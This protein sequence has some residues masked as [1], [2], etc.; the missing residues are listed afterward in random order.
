MGWGRLK[1]NFLCV[2]T[3]LVTPTKDITLVSA[4][5][6]SCESTVSRHQGH[7]TKS[8]WTKCQGTM[9]QGTRIQ[10][11]TVASRCVASKYPPVDDG[12]GNI[13]SSIASNTTLETKFWCPSVSTIKPRLQRPTVNSHRSYTYRSKAVAWIRFQP[14]KSNLKQRI[15]MLVFT[16]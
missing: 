6:D 16:A 3:V 10:G 11:T 7:G 1:P 2:P 14:Q 9:G 12:T 5:L 13:Y 8:R 4:Y 15:T